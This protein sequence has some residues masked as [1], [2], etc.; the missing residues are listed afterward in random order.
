MDQSTRRYRPVVVAPI[1]ARFQ[2]EGF[3][4]RNA[5]LVAAALSSL[6][7]AAFAAPSD[8][9]AD[10]STLRD[11][12]SRLSVDGLLSADASSLLQDRELTRLQA[13]RLLESGL[14]LSD[15]GLS[16]NL[17]K[18][19]T[20]AVRN[21]L[22]GLRPELI[23]DHVDV[24]GILKTL[25]SDSTS[26]LGMIEPEA[27]IDTGGSHNPGSGTI[28]IYRGT[29]VGGLG[30]NAQ[31]GVSISDQAEE[32]RRVF[33][34]DIGPHDFSAVSQ[35]YVQFDGDRGLNFLIGRTDD[36]W[37]P[38]ASGGALLSDN[39]P[40][41][42]QLRVSFPFSFGKH[43]GR[44]WNYTQLAATYDQD[45]TRTYFQARRIDINFNHRWSAQY[46]EALKATASSMLLRAP[47][48]FLI[49]KSINLQGA[50]G[51]SEFIANLG[52]EYQPATQFRAYG[53]LLINDVKS[54]FR[55]HVLGLDLGTGTNTPQRLA[56]LIGASWQPSTLTSANVEYSIS[57]PTTYTDS[58]AQLNWTK[59]AY[60]YLGLPG[61]PN[62]K[63]IYASLTQKVASKV[64]VLLEGRLRQRFSDGYPAPN[65]QD[66]AATA[67]YQLDRRNS[68]ALTYHDYYQDAYPIAPGAPG[69]PGGD[70]Y[71][72]VSNS[73]PGFSTT[74]HELDAAYTFVF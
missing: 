41:L 2:Q 13:A 47:L 17:K 8:I 70:G 7:P 52:A 20:G 33:Q 15:S 60:N 19:D 36:N 55:G 21:V 11:S 48:P 59:G 61:G 51:N 9:I 73:N 57:D 35:A 28:G 29:A 27:R 72:A 42:D 3:A 63:Q 14:G 32:N 67:R 37:G 31:Y 34:N 43:L 39:A 12:L 53:Q 68:F 69:Y 50:E 30:E 16:T 56:Y 58:N 46:E 62:F 49:G 64:T 65:T 10:N 74:I 23:A 44:N 5:L 71:I 1:R 66:L 22:E 26:F 38:G 45:N 24:D 4:L 6:V 25:S 40:P 54:P 18:G